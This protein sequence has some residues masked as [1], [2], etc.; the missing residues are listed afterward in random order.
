MAMLLSNAS[1]ERLG[2]KLQLSNHHQGG[3]QVVISL[4]LQYIDK[5]KV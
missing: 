2:G 1:F 4:P 3:A 5:Q